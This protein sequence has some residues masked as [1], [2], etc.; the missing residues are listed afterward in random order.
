MDIEILHRPS[1]SLA[2]TKRR[3]M[4][5]SVLKEARWSA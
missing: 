5:A 3:Q 2:V 1:Y 4:N